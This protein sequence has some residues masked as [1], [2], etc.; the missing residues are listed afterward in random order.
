MLNALL[1][2]EPECKWPLATATFIGQALRIEPA[3]LAEQLR[4]LQRIDSARRNFY[5]RQLAELPA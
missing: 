4:T 2:M 1:E 3:Q 5:E